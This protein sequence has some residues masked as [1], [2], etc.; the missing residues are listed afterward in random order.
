[1]GYALYLAQVEEKHSRARPL[2]GFAGASVLEIVDDHDG[3]T[4]RCV[5]TVR[6]V[7]QFTPCM[8]SRRSQRAA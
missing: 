3:D 8:L 6:F 1:M 2:R 7:R 5:Y 4:Y